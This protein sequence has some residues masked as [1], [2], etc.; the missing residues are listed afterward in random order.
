MLDKEIKNACIADMWFYIRDLKNFPS[1]KK[2]ELKDVL[3]E[4][5]DRV[6]VIGYIEGLKKAGKRERSIIDD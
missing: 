4:A 6:Y 5:L 3:E 1:V 2:L